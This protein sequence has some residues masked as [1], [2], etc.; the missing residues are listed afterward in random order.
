MF[1]KNDP[2]E[3]F[4]TVKR[5]FPKDQEELVT[6]NH[7]DTVGF[8]LQLMKENNFSQLPVIRDSEVFGVFSYRSLSHSI[9]AIGNRNLDKIENMCKLPVE[10]CM[11]DPLGFVDLK[12][13]LKNII[14][15]LQIRDAL[16][17]GSS[18][19]PKGIVTSVDAL[20]GFYKIAS[21]YFMLRSIELCL[22]TLLNQ[23][24]GYEGIQEVSK[25]YLRHYNEVP[26]RIEDLT[27]TDVINLVK[28]RK[29][30]DK[31]KGAFGGS[32]EITRGRLDRIPDIR[33]DILHFKRDISGE[34]FGILEDCLRWL[35]RRIRQYPGLEI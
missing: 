34:E 3:L 31:L 28:N 35:T 8:A 19:N 18:S 24:L 10:S 20:V 12:D 15:E 1:N 27:L 23:A 4:L 21:P 22:R 5:I 26:D 2:E 6:V 30:W 17:L 25:R 11:E 13:K 9:L 7:D 14:S 29:I 33:N 32:Y 16:L